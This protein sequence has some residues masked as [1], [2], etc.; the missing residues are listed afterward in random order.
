MKE[1]SH[2]RWSRLL[3]AVCA[4]KDTQMTHRCNNHCIS[5]NDKEIWVY[6]STVILLEPFEQTLN[7]VTFTVF[8]FLAGLW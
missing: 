1:K 7:L 8:G 2:P 5:T 6:T 3:Q 4:F